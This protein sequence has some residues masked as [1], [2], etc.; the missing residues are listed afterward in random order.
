MQ[1][2][3]STVDGTNKEIY[4]KENIVEMLEMPLLPLLRKAQKIHLEYFPIDEVQLASLL[5]IK[6]GSCPEDCKYCPQSAHYA[7]KTELQK[8]SLMNT[9]D[10]L[11]KAKI[12]KENGATRFCMGAA[13]RKIPKGKQFE[14]ILSMVR[15][16]KEMGMEA[17]VTLGTL[18]KEEAMLLKEAGLDAYNHNIDTSP[19]FYKKII[20]T[21]HF[22]ERL[23]TIKHVIDAKISVCSGGIIGMGESIEDRAEML[24]IL[25]N[26]DPYP[27]SVPI[28]AL[29]P[30]KGTPLEHRD[31]IDP[32]ELV[33]MIAAARISMPKAKI[34]LSAGRSNLSKEAQALCFLAGANSIFYG[35]KLLTTQNND[36]QADKDLLKNL[37][38]IAYRT[39]H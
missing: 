4:S 6:T 38:G 9:E 23:E 22:N 19:K 15:G 36:T 39:N 30:V 35:E 37:F 16:V 33:R 26:L 11:K 7:N 29:V 12:A 14:S 18:N 13:W 8:E 34:R 3:Q 32:L 17:C 24:S 27:E 21:R 25:A 31:I 1:E 20:S 2:I 28:N 10:V 5:S